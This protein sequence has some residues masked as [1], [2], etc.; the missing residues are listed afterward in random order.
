MGWFFFSS[1]SLYQFPLRQFL[2]MTLNIIGV[3]YTCLR[4]HKYLECTS[5][6]L[7]RLITIAISAFCITYVLFLRT[8]VV[9]KRH[10]PDT[11]RE[12]N[13]IVVSL[14][15]SANIR[16]RTQRC[17]AV[18]RAHRQNEMQHCSVFAEPI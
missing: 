4:H 9:I 17:T 12:F 13:K 16:N 2:E 15:T 14:L 11:P 18:N 5:V 3:K 6:I 7:C 10:L 8:N 1:P